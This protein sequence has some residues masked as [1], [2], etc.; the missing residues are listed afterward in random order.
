MMVD[1]N[2]ITETAAS[3]MGFRGIKVSI[4]SDEIKVFG[5]F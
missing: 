1:E 3:M 4:R 5:R 2:W